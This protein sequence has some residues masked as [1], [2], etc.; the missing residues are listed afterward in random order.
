MVMEFH[1]LQRVPLDLPYSLTIELATSIT[2][3]F[4]RTIVPKGIEG[5][6]ASLAQLDRASLF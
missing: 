6:L 5:S 1:E 4:K 3:G 2:L